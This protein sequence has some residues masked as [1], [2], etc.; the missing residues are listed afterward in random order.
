MHFT[1]SVTAAGKTIYA[2]TYDDFAAGNANPRDNL[3]R[4]K[5]KSE[6]IFNAATGNLD[7]VV[8]QYVY[9][10]AGR[11]WR[12][13]DGSG[14]VTED[15]EYDA[16]GNRTSA[17]V[18]GVAVTN[19]Q[20]DA[21]D[22]LLTYGATTFTYTPNGQRQTM[23]RSGVTTIYGWD[24]YGNLTSVS[25]GTTRIEYQYDAQQ[26]RIARRKW[27]TATATP[28]LLAEEHYLY[29]DQYRI[30]AT[31][32]A[33]NNVISRYVYGTHVNVPDYVVSGGVT[34]RVITDERGS[35][36]QLVN[37]A[38]GAPLLRFDYA[39]AFGN[40]TANASATS[41]EY[42]GFAGGL[43]DSDTGLIHFGARDYDPLLG[44]WLRKDPLGFDASGTNF[45][46]YAAND[47]VNYVDT[48]GRDP[49]LTPLLPSSP[50]MPPP[51]LVPSGGSAIESGEGV[52]LVAESPGAGVIG[53]LGPV[54]IAG[55]AGIGIGLIIDGLWGDRIQHAMDAVFGDPTIPPAMC[56]G[57]NKGERGRTR[58]P[59]GTNNP[60]K[61]YKPDPNDPTKVIYKDQNGKN[62]TKNKPPGFDDWWNS[63]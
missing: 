55:A 30:V 14:N 63:R 2:A 59:D 11:L 33:S 27:N 4:I 21:Q 37:S 53:V 22:R 38:T 6:S 58:S 46:A 42:F 56:G 45:Y 19:I 10:S 36:R 50:T 8:K 20:V 48:T 51:G 62:Q 41:T 9:D 24:G 44:E 47:P 43:T 7:T 52:M 60:F 23:V 28:A 17:T 40:P 29:G 1:Y 12:V 54:A 35:V 18:N 13:L 61:K 39:D 25:W 34:Y 5:R 49:S 26:R 15:Y 16:N 3:G 32:D 57:R 31:L